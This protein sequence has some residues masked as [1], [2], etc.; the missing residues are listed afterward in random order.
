MEFRE[1]T[2]FAYLNTCGLLFRSCLTKRRRTLQFVF[3]YCNIFLWAY[4]ISFFIL[5]LVYLIE[6]GDSVLQDIA[7]DLHLHYLNFLISLVAFC[8]VSLIFIPFSL[9]GCRSSGVNVKI[10]YFKTGTKSTCGLVVYGLFVLLM[11]IF[12]VTLSSWLI[13]Q[14]FPDI[15]TNALNSYIISQINNRDYGT[16]Q[17]I[18]DYQTRNHCC[19]LYFDNTNVD[20]YK[21]N[22]YGI[23]L[24]KFDQ[25]FVNQHFP[26]IINAITSDQVPSCGGW[27]GN[28]PIGCDCYPEEDSELNCLT[29]DQATADYNCSFPSV[30]QGSK[31]F[32]YIYADSCGPLIYQD[33]IKVNSTVEAMAMIFGIVSLMV[34]FLSLF[35]SCALFDNFEMYE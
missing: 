25:Y 21:Q 7:E 11:G 18:I 14:N 15:V 27:L 17:A 12:F 23:Q 2:C 29:L 28:I 19:G 5:T 34:A 26:K 35:L 6:T 31:N 33:F 3:F 22:S 24:N 4:S 1:T 10:I 32:T 13:S 9:I 20:I 8:I 16:T 30:K